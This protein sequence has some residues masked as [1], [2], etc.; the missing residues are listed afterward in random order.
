MIADRQDGPHAHSTIEL[1]DGSLI[2]ADLGTDELVYLERMDF[3]TDGDMLTIWHERAPWKLPAGSGPRH[4]ELSPNGRYLYVLTE[5]SCEIFVFDLKRDHQIVG[6]YSVRYRPR[7]QEYL[8]DAIED[9][10][11]QNLSA[12]I[13]LS[14]DGKHLYVS[15]RG[16][17]S[18]VIF[19]VKSRGGSLE[20]QG[21]YSCGGKGPRS[22]AIS[23]DYIVIANQGTANVVVRKLNPNGSIGLPV[24][25]FWVP[26]ASKVLLL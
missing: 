15:N 18:I 10:W 13:H 4:M 6:R 22:F 23:E 11:G 20:L 24:R 19:N 1:P 14:A 25:E 2:T 21:A 3:D 17:D 5:L 9:A 7:N 16:L 26:R 12:D 8:G